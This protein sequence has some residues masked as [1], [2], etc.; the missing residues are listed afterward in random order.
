MKKIDYDLV[1]KPA[2][3][4][5]AEQ[6]HTETVRKPHGED[7]V[8]TEGSIHHPEVRLFSATVG[9][10]H[11]DGSCDILI[12]PPNRDHK[13]VDRVKQGTKPGEFELV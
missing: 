4:R 13:W 12:F 2:R 1:G 9:R 10:V 3:Y 5:V 6:H 11:E 8:K 7:E